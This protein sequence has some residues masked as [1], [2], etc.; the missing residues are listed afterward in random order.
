MKNTLPHQSTPWRYPALQLRFVGT[1]SIKRD[2]CEY[3][4][5]TWRFQNALSI[6]PLRLSSAISFPKVCFAVHTAP[7]SCAAFHLAITGFP[8][9]AA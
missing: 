3:L 2:G 7:E 4:A 6:S 9:G 8:S 1:L 5:T